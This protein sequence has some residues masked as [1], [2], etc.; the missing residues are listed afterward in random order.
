MF[1]IHKIKNRICKVEWQVA[2]RYRESRELD[3]TLSRVPFTPIP[4]SFRYWAADPF[5]ID[6]KGET[7][8][9]VELYDRLKRKGL[10][11]YMN[12]TNGDI[13]KY[14]IVFE[15]NCHL[16]YPYVFEIDG[17]LFAVPESNNIEKLLFLKWD[18]KSE[19][20][21]LVYTFMEGHS[22]ADSNF[23]LWNKS[24]YM[25][26][27]PVSKSDNVGTLEIY[28]KVAD[29][30]YVP[31]S[32]NPVVVD[33]TQARNGGKIILKN[34]V[35]YRIS[36]DC[37]KGYGSGLNILRI[38]NISDSDYKETLVKKVFPNSL[39][40]SGYQRID[41]IHTY[42]C[43]DKF[44]VIDFKFNHKFSIAEFFGF[45]LCKFHIFN[46]IVK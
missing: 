14:K 38:D 30:K 13:S 21:N 12:I 29:K 6:F 22:L 41:G 45:F 37:G 7:L 1:L 23:L 44:E 25:L 16:S 46:K 10:L 36:Q 19:K 15:T 35:F 42:N 26:T 28:K 2:L 4:N 3:F 43:N 11:G 8:L 5:I 34:G 27:T 40:V 24:L 32:K 31:C 18:E 33:K 9:F 17:E 39:V 20:F